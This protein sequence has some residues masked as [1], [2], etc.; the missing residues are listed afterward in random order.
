MS[1]IDIVKSGGMMPN[2]IMF[3]RSGRTYW[4]RARNGHWSIEDQNFDKIVLEGEHPNA[5]WWSDKEAEKFLL[6]VTDDWMP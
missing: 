2:Q 6:S 5:G 4:F 3:R 1:L